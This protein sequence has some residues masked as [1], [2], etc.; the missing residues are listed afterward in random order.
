MKAKELRELSPDELV[1]KRQELRQELFSAR[2]RHATGQL[3]DTAR[4]N[5]LRRDIARLETVLHDK[6]GGAA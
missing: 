6:R 1:A 2:V 4:L 5:L 3:E